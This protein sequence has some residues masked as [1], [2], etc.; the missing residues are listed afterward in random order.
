MHAPQKV[1]SKSV[2][3]QRNYGLRSSKHLCYSSPSCSPSAS[4]SSM[5]SLCKFCR[6]TTQVKYC[7]RVTY[8]EKILW[9]RRKDFTAATV[10]RLDLEL[11]RNSCSPICARTPSNDLKISPIT[12]QSRLP[13]C[14]MVTYVPQCNKIIGSTSFWTITI[15]QHGCLHLKTNVQN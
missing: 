4:L 10:S 1:F 7:E 3:A 2:R 9:G 12:S 11:A 13:P 15:C 6:A 8:D 14:S 5:D